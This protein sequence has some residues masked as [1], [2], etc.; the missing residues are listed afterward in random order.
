MT[1]Q[2]TEMKQIVTN[3]DMNTITYTE[4]D[5]DEDEK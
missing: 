2:S 3:I 4:P 5:S 1:N